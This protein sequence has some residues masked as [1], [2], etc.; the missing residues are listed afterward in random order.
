[1]EGDDV[2]IITQNDEN[3]DMNHSEPLTDDEE[4][5]NITNENTFDEPFKIGDMFI[6]ITEEDD[7]KEDSL[8]TIQEVNIEE[9]KIYLKDENENDF[10]FSL[11]DNNNIILKTNEYSIFEIEK[12]DEFDIDELDNVDL[13]ITKNIFPEIELDIIET[14]E[15]IFTYQERKENLITELISL[16]NAYNNEPLIYQISD[17][18]NHFLK[19][20]KEDDKIYDYSE[21]LPFIK[22]ILKCPLFYYIIIY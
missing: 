2:Q 12:V 8:M 3:I 17:I 22:D 11:D 18:S 19:M 16:Y 7:F 5:E 9:K 13:M 10:F 1:M 15:K 4:D 20:L 21:T 6:I 14:K